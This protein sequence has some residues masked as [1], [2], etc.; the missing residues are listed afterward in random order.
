MG[1][2]KVLECDGCGKELDEASD[3]YEFKPTILLKSD[4]YTDAAGSGDNN[5]ISLYFCGRCVSNLK[6]TLEKILKRMEA[7]NDKDN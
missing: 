3:R 7:K 4:R 6:K 5:Y 1:Y 2:R